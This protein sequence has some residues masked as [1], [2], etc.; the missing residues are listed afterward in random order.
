MATT[1]RE[2]ELLAVTLQLLQRHGYERLTVDEV[3]ANAHAS[4]A[5][6]YRRWPTKADLVFAAVLDGISQDATA[7]ETGTLR[8]D[9][10]AIGDTVSKHVREHAAT[11]RAVLSETSRDPALGDIIRREFFEE[12]RKLTRQVMQQAIDRGEIRAGSVNEDLWDLLPGYLVFRAVIQN[13]PATRKTVIALV[14]EV[15]LP[16]LTR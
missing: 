1:A 16:S 4:K 13:R 7:P 14:D 2:G 6:M 3:A 11:L 12:R 15:I 9:L 10:L 5:T 8:G